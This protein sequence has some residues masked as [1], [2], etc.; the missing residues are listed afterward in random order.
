[1]GGGVSRNIERARERANHLS[2]DDEGAPVR[3]LFAWLRGATRGALTAA[4]TLRRCAAEDNDEHFHLMPKVWM[5]R[6]LHKLA[7]GNFVE[8]Y[9]TQQEL[10]RCCRWCHDCHDDALS[11]LCLCK[12]CAASS[13]GDCTRSALSMARLFIHVCPPRLC[14]RSGRFG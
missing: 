2:S 7:N 1:M 4:H 6:S 14:G 8:E 3:P 11:L 13:A 9:K 10:R 5:N 12:R